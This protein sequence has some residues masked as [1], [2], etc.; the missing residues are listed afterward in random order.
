MTTNPVIADDQVAAYK[1]KGYIVVEDIYSPADV[2][3]MRDALD[4]LIAS[5]HGLTDHTNVIDLEPNHT[6][7]R[8]RVRRIKEP[9]KN[10]DVF[11]RM[12]R[13]PRLIAALTALL[14]PAFRMHGSKINLKS[15]E[16]GSPVE[17]HQD[18]AFYP[19][20]NDDVL[21]VGVMLDDMTEEN[22]P[23]LCVPGSHTGPTYD[24]HQDGRFIG[25][26]DPDV[27]GAN[28]GS[29]ETITGPAGACSFHHARTIHGSGQNTSGKGRTLL[30]YQIAAA[31]AWDIRGFGKEASW[32]E[33]AATFIAGEPTLE[34]RVVPTPIRLPY[35]P[36]LKGGSIYESQ[37]LAKKK[38]FG[39]KTA[40]E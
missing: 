15:A 36:P 28:L 27:P 6:P 22:G 20:T 2:Q 26:M 39:A 19:H 37:S 17:W 1:N 21:A 30:L 10:H 31:D 33:Y 12:A 16:Y 4:G 9:F 18:W 8:P 40:A 29:A 7:D 5:A 23:L 3:E 14:G 34:P 35:P 11:N 38:F 25:A 24:H 13:H 32:D